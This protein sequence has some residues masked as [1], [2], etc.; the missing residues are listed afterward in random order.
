MEVRG[1]RE[2]LLDDVM[3]ALDEF[4]EAR[5]AGRDERTALDVRLRADGE[6]IRKCA[7]LRQTFSRQ[8]TPHE[9]AEAIVN[10]EETLDIGNPQKRI[11][12]AQSV[13]KDEKDDR[14]ILR[15]GIKMREELDKK[16]LKLDEERL[17]TEKDKR[18]ATESIFGNFKYLMKNA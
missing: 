9:S 16:R 11:S 10:S 5:R 15:E 14:D 3:V 6:D 7:V 1:D 2:V 18:E 13:T 8:S 17:N 12:R 4:E